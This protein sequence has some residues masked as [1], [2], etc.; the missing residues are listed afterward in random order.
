MHKPP[1]VKH[2]DWLPLGLPRLVWSSWWLILYALGTLQRPLLLHS[3]SAWIQGRAYWF[4]P[5]WLKGS[6]GFLH[7]HNVVRLGAKRCQIHEAPFFLDECCNLFAPSHCPAKIFSQSS[8]MY[9]RR[10]KGRD[11]FVWTLDRALAS[12]RKIHSCDLHFGASCRVQNHHAKPQH[13]IHMTLQGFGKEWQHSCKNL[14]AT[15]CSEALFLYVALLAPDF[16]TCSE[17]QHQ[18]LKK[19]MVS[20]CQRLK[21][22]G[23]YWKFD[24]NTQ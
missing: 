18:S 23:I 3:F 9:S 21:S 17:Y 19:W 1:S 20:E 16:E 8:L 15:C 22:A 14:Q 5:S 6:R 2:P 12:E 11:I 4:S 7:R 13:P 10:G 24:E